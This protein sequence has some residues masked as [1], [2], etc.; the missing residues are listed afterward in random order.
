MFTIYKE[1]LLTTTSLDKILHVSSYLKQEFGRTQNKFVLN[2]CPQ[3]TSEFM[4]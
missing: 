4:K 2:L 1:M 3:E